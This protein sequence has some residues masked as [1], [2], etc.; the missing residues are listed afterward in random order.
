VAITTTVICLAYI[1]GLLSTGLPGGGFFVLLGGG[2]LSWAGPRYWR[3]GPRS[4]LWLVAGLVG[5]L[6]SLYWQWRIPQP[7]ENDISRLISAGGAERI[8]VS[9]QGDVDSL[10]RR[11]RNDSQQFWLQVRQMED[12]PGPDPQQPIAGK[13]YVTALK[14]TVAA[15][16]QPGQRIRLRGTLSLPKPP[17]NPGGFDFRVY[18]QQ[19]GCFAALRSNRIQVIDAQARW[20][21]WQV[22]QRIVR[23]QAQ[24]IPAAEGAL[25]SAMVLGGRAVDLP[26]EV[27]DEF[28]RVGLA[29]AL[30]ASGF[31]TSL[32]LG[33]VLALCRR[34]PERAQFAVGTSAL[35]LFVGLAG[36]QPAVL[37]AALMGFGGLVALVLE[38][39]IRPLGSLLVTAT[40]LLLFNPLWIW[41]LGFQLSF[42]ATLGLLVAVPPITQRLNWLPIAIAPLVAVP[43]AAYAWTLPLCLYAF[44]IVSP[45]SIF[46]NL[47]TTPLIS[48]LS[49]GGMASAL[50][51]LVWSP[52]GSGS[53]WLLKFPAQW[54]IAIVHWFGQLPGN[55]WA[56]GT[57]S[58]GMAIALYGLL[59]LTW[60]QS[61]WQ[62]RG[63]LA[64][65]LGLGLVSIPAWQMRLSQ[66]QVTILATAGQPALVVQDAG[67]TGLIQT[68]KTAVSIVLP[69]LQKAGVNRLDWVLPLQLQQPSGATPQQAPTVSTWEKLSER[70]PIQT[71]YALPNKPNDFWL[72]AKAAHRPQN[73]AQLHPGQATQIGSIQMNLLTRAPALVEFQMPDQKWLWLEPANLEAQAQLLKTGH[74][75]PVQV[76]WWSGQRLH[77]ELIKAVQPK[78]AIASAQRVNPKTVADLQATGT[79][80]YWTG[81]DGALQWTPKEGFKTTLNSGIN[82]SENAAAAL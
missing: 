81:R 32:I 15:Q 80:L 64:L 52:L 10:P 5:L 40:L 45:Y 42:L 33:V 23:S 38:R 8:E 59:S 62:K 60:L 49:L 68:D 6:A 11:T 21:L 47:V 70:L 51:A 71:A 37:R 48:V 26:V 56:L 36:A 14:D 19:E 54:L 3:G 75:A 25:I 27:K 41:D 29:H 50:A 28:V 46:A 63:W 57:I 55:A 34:W 4:R 39:K 35:L 30:A 18:L 78:V 65:L 79:E 73:Q 76:L 72:Q 67:R 66:F 69:F 17:T 61:W 31:Q 58:A 9:L 24:W 43:I 12:F 16:L 44:G 13:L 22:Q 2:V 82:S 20:G 74:L 1:L 77:P 7:P 53:A